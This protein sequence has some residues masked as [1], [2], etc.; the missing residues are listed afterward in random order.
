MNTRL[1]LVVTA[2]LLI[3]DVTLARATMFTE[4]VFATGGAIGAT[5]PDSVLYGAGSLWIAYQNGAASDGSSGAS[6][7]VR[8]SF[9]GTVQH[10]W[11]IAGNVDGLRIDPTGTVWA[12]Q[13]NDG[14]STLT[15]INPG[16]NA[17]AL[18]TY[19]STYTNTANRGFDDAEFSKGMTF[20]SETNPASPTDPI[21]LALTT[22]LASPLQVKGLLNAGTIT[23]PDSLILMPNGDLALTGEAD[24]TIIF[25]HN[26]GTASQTVS[27]LPLKGVGAGSPDDTIFPTASQGTFFYADT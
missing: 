3:F 26:P 20:L 19:G 18:Y 24:Q 8:Y 6:T 23:D 4:S 1:G 2:A 17:T 10:Q 14:N 22:P 7:V 15:T 12:M 25:I 13:N 27:Y 16:T 21:L 11:T 9:S 5:S